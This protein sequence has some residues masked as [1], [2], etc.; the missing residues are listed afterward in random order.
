M[1]KRAREDRRMH[2]EQ[3]HPGRA[4]A[5]RM[6]CL[7]RRRPPRRRPFAR[8]RRSAEP[9]R[10]R[11]AAPRPRAALS[12][13]L[14]S[15]LEAESLAAVRAEW[16]RSPRGRPRGRRTSTRWRIGCW[17][18]RPFRSS[19]A[20][21]SRRRGARRP[22]RTPASRHRRRRGLRRDLARDGPVEQGAVRTRGND[23]LETL[24]T[25]SM[26]GATSPQRVSAS[27]RFRARTSPRKA[28]SWCHMLGGSVAN[29]SGP[30]LRR[31]DLLIEIAGRS[32]R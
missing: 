15:V 32:P 30:T 6:A 16:A 20:G 13:A 1:R 4:E 29:V 2:E 25:M 3:S 19:S 10:F 24:G 31:V 11:R 8:R 12:P 5:S 27:Q 9:R 18:S 28:P 7:S 14:R 22:V 26:P 23:L 21:A 17:S